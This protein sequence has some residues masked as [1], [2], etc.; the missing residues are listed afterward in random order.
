[1]CEREARGRSY[2]GWGNSSLDEQA[3]KGIWGFR[4]RFWVMSTHATQFTANKL[5]VLPHLV[6]THLGN[7]WT[8]F[9]VYMIASSFLVL[10]FFASSNCQY[11]VLLC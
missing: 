8:I 9:L 4:R 6:T 7:H 2:R 1:V 3:T 5:M 10:P 11:G